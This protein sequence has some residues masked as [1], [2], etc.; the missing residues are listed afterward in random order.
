MLL[1]QNVQE[2][3]SP[4]NE[5]VVQAAANNPVWP[6]LYP[7]DGSVPTQIYEQL[8]GISPDTSVLTIQNGVFIDGDGYSVQS[9]DGSVGLHDSLLTAAGISAIKVGT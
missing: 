5:D 4:P 2:Y 9:V 1:T 3:I 8:A 6:I 7:S